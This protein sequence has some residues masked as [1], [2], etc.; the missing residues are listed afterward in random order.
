MFQAKP[1]LC[2]MWHV[3]LYPYDFVAS[4]CGFTDIHCESCISQLRVADCEGLLVFP[5]DCRPFRS[6]Y[7]FSIS[8]VMLR[9]V[10]ISAGWHLHPSTRKLLQVNSENRPV[11]VPTCR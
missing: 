11:V 6:C 9:F 3:H 2:P 1:L 5:P 8:A 7:R 4:Y 10:G